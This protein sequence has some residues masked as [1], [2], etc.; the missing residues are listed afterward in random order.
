MARGMPP[1][2]FLSL[3]AKLI[4]G[5]ALRLRLPTISAGQ[6]G[7]SSRAY[8]CFVQVFSRRRRETFRALMRP[9]AERRQCTKS[10]RELA[11]RRCRG[12]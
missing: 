7:S 4:A 6:R 3:R 11:R 2:T 12:R 8:G 5:L 10:R 1:D 9:A